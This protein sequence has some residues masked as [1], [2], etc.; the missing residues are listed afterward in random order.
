MC[1]GYGDGGLKGNWLQVGSRAPMAKA[2]DSV[3]LHSAAAGLVSYTNSYCSCLDS[4]SLG[5]WTEGNGETTVVIR[6][7]GWG[8]EFLKEM[9][10]RGGKVSEPPQPTLWDFR[11]SSDFF[12]FFL[13]PSSPFFPQVHSLSLQNRV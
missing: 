9:K 4:V 11:E 5:A 2:P 8:Q 6:L 3:F 13:K 7:A 10:A 12:F 1:L